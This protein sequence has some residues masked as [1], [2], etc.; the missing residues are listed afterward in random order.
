MEEFS[1]VRLKDYIFYYFCY[2]FRRQVNPHYK[3]LEVA[4]VLQ[5]PQDLQKWRYNPLDTGAMRVAYNRLA[6]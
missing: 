2:T 1:T 5:V 4:S 6:V 3:L